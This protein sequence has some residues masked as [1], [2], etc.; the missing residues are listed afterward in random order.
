MQGIAVAT[1]VEVVVGGGTGKSVCGRS[2]VC[3]AY[4]CL[5]SEES[6]VW[7]NPNLNWSNAWPNLSFSPRVSSFIYVTQ[8]MMAFTIHVH[9]LILLRQAEVEE[10]RVTRLVVNVRPSGQCLSEALCDI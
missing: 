8:L 10:V 4:Y 2:K 5:H 3:L 9:F 6:G 1:L 7:H